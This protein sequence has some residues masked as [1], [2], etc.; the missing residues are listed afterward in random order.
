MTKMNH[1]HVISVWLC[2]ST[3]RN[4]QARY[5]RWCNEWRRGTKSRVRKNF[6]RQPQR[7]WLRWEPM[8]AIE[9]SFC[10]WDCERKW[11]GMERPQIISSQHT[12][13]NK[14]KRRRK[15]RAVD[16]GQAMTSIAGVISILKLTTTANKV[17]FADLAFEWENQFLLPQLVAGDETFPPFT[18]CRFYDKV[19]FYLRHGK[20]LYRQSRTDC[21]KANEKRR[22]RGSFLIKHLWKLESR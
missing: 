12:K 15:G 17:H 8:T 4:S 21:W 19:P 7:K 20:S 2:R 13:I 3:S 9:T 14:A 22:P 18:L 11:K 16:D 10:G 1:P 6:S 5:K